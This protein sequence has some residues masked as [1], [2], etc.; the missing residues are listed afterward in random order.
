MTMS[1][2]PRPFSP[3]RHP[4]TIALVV[5]LVASLASLQVVATALEAIQ[6]DLNNSQR[7]DGFMAFEEQFVWMNVCSTAIQLLGLTAAA[8]ALALVFVWCFSAKPGQSSEGTRTM[9]AAGSTVNRTETTVPNSS[10]STSNSS[11]P[12]TIS[13]S[14]ERPRE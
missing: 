9:S 14:T 3:I 12:S 13:I 6:S 5:V 8:S 10:P 2:A 1:G 7:G 4:A 11:A